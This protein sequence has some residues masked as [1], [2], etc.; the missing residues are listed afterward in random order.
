MR[1]EQAPI[2][3]AEMFGERRISVRAVTHTEPN[4]EL[5]AKAVDRWRYR[6]TSKTATVESSCST[7][8]RF[9]FALGYRWTQRDACPLECLA[10]G[11]RL[12]T[13][14]PTNLDKRVIVAV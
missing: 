10:D 8:L 11:A 1:G 6:T 12:K 9:V 7:A 4:I 3:Y 13:E 5:L 14:Q 2:G